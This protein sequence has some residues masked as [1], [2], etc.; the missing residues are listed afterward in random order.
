MYS[1][2]SVG[3]RV[4]PGVKGGTIMASP[5]LPLQPSYGS[6]DSGTAMAIPAWRQSVRTIHI[7]A[8]CSMRLLAMKLGLINICTG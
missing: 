8:C 1:V 3:K 5:A 2:L 4:V 7:H 6:E